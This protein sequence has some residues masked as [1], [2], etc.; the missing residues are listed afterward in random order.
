MEDGDKGLCDREAK[1]RFGGDG[2]WG[3]VQGAGEDLRNGDWQ[4]DGSG[5]CGRGGGRDRR[6]EG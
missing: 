6:A 4:W 5:I 3:G 1:G 2:I